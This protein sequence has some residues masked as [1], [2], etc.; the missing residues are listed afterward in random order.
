MPRPSWS[1]AFVGH[2]VLG[3]RCSIRAV[4]TEV[5]IDSASDVL[6]L[7]FEATRRLGRKTS[8]SGVTRLQ[9]L[10]FL[11]SKSAEYKQLEA[12]GKAPDLGFRAYKMGPFTTEIYSGLEVLTS[13]QRPLLVA[14]QAA[15]PAVQDEVDAREFAE[16]ADLD[17]GYP[18]RGPVPIPTVF[19][20]TAA[21]E[22]V[23]GHLWR[24]APVGLTAAI[25]R[26]VREYGELPLRQLLRRVYSEYGAYTTRSEIKGQL[27]LA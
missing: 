8:L 5:S 6:L 23:A 22:L 27:R 14:R 13:F 21:G 12:D 19:A 10:T 25:E 1:D 11:V 15:E 4:G 16:D 9:K 7:L 24:L 17:Q 2:F 3:R 20:L 26:V 18:A